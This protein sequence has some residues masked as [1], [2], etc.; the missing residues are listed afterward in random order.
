MPSSG[1]RKG[2]AC[3]SR[4]SATAGATPTRSPATGEARLDHDRARSTSFRF[5]PWTKRAAGSTTSPRPT[6]PTQRYLY[7]SR[8]DGKGKPERVTPAD[9]PGHAHLQHLSGRPLGVPRLFE[10]RFA[11]AV[12]PRPSARSQGRPRVPGQR[13]PQGQGRADARRPDRDVPGRHRRRR[14]DRRLAD[15]AGEVRS[16]RRN[17]RSSSTSTASRPRPRSTTAGAGRD[18]S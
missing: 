18:G 17:T 13:R 12:R 6:T 16:R 10:V 9:A 4:A 2:S 5:R 14:E 1:S 7:R 3:C 8:L 15:P 11:G